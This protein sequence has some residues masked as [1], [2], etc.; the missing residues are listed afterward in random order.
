MTSIP[1]Q[2]VVYAVYVNGK[3]VADVILNVSIEMGWGMH[4]I[5]TV[6]IEYNRGE[7]MSAITPWPDNA[8]VSISWGTGTTDLNTWYGYL[9]HYQMKS[10][11]TSGSHNL[12]MIYVCIGAS[13][14]MNNQTGATWGNVTPTYIAKF[15][16]ARYGFRCVVTSGAP[17]MQNVTQAAQSDFQF[18]N[19]LADQCGYRFWCSNGTLYFVDPLIYF[20]GTFV[21]GVPIFNQDKKQF[22]QDT[23]RDFTVLRGDNLP[24]ATVANRI[25]YGVDSA[26][27]NLISASTGSSGTTLVNTT[28]SINSIAS[29][30]QVIDAW[31]G[32]SQFWIGAK[33]ELF[34]EQGLYPGKLV[35]LNGSALP[36]NNIGYW[37]IGRAKH[38]LLMSGTTN[39]VNDKY[40]VQ[41]EL[42]RNTQGPQPKYQNVVT[43]S[44][45]IVKC[46][47]TSGNWQAAD[48]RV[49]IDGVSNGA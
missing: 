21:Q 9:N 45:E 23:I 2:P 35:Y 12:E 47:S 14:P 17:I 28:A 16:A 43:V 1:V 24:G 30:N 15:M 31:Q 7:D 10:N 18:L 6:R 13:K 39:P 3:T 22:Q 4:D 19:Y 49:I 5:A 37:V 25:V 46:V 27:G 48:Q 20:Q 32:L 40:V 8:L 36:G 11:A 33:A 34:G 26:T 41:V 42:L 38:L 44:P 29:G